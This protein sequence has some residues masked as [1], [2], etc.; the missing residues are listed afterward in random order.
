MGQYILAT[1][2]INHDPM[3]EILMNRDKDP[4][5][6]DISWSWGW[7]IGPELITLKKDLEYFQD[8]WFKQPMISEPGRQKVWGNTEEKNQRLCLMALEDLKHHGNLEISMALKRATPPHQ[9]LPQA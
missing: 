1:P 4:L 8:I 6:Q 7:E 3:K 2:Q 9:S 5:Y